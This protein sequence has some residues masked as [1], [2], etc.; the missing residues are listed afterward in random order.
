M[1]RSVPEGR[2]KIAGFRSSLRDEDDFLNRPPNV[3][4][5][6]YCRMSLRDNTFV[7]QWNF[8]KSLGLRPVGASQGYISSQGPNDL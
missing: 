4:T 6:G 3:E 8:R 7:G 2:L 1:R 5:L